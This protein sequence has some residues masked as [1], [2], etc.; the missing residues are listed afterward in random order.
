MTDQLGARACRR[1]FPRP[2]HDEGHVRAAVPEIGFVT[3]S[4]PAGGMP[5]LGVVRVM[6]RT[7]VAGKGNMLAEKVLR[8]ARG[9]VVLGLAPDCIFITEIL[10]KSEGDIG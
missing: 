9:D 6:N 4:V 10:S 7:F 3:A 8:W 5:E 1:D 2:T